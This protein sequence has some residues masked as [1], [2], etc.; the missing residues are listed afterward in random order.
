MKSRG[1][2][3]EPYSIIQ[4]IEIIYSHKRA[5]TKDDKGK[6]A[7]SKDYLPSEIVHL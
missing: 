1:F 5:M 2:F 6:E 7:L 4:G 3:T